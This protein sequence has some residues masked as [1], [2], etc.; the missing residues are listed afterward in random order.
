LDEPKAGVDASARES[1]WKVF[2]EAKLDRC[3]LCCMH[4]PLKEAA[5]SDKNGI[6]KK[7]KLMNKG[8]E[9]KLI[10]NYGD[11]YA[12]HLHFH[13]AGEMS[14]TNLLEA[15]KGNKVIQLLEVPPKWFT[16]KYYSNAAPSYS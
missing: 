10:S 9:Y 3:I 6:L 11:G 1:M 4:T 15:L 7:G 16:F 14:S 12:I 2:R 5:L 8:T 13:E